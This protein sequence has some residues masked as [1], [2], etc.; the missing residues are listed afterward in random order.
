MARKRSLQSLINEF[1]RDPEKAIVGL[2]YGLEYINSK[3]NTIAAC[4][5]MMNYTH[6]VINVNERF[7][8]NRSRFC[9]DEAADISRKAASAHELA[10]AH[11]HQ[12]ALR[13]RGVIFDGE[14][15]YVEHTLERAANIFAARF[16]IDLDELQE[17]L[18]KG[19]SF[20]QIAK[21][22]KVPVGFAVLRLE[23]LKRAKP[24]LGIGR[25]PRVRDD[26]MACLQMTDESDDLYE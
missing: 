6:P 24:E 1:G 23:D 10:H 4:T 14:M 25:L 2:G 19:Y 3:N 16:L 20:R 22:L 11:I 8:A 15:Y 21:S 12:P 18:L 17:S 7:F 26:F 9:C 13:K 5:M